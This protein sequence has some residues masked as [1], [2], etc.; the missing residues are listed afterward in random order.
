MRCCNCLAVV[1]IGWNVTC[2]WRVLQ[3]DSLPLIGR[4][5]RRRARFTPTRA[6]MSRRSIHLW[7]I[8]LLSSAIALPHPD[9]HLDLPIGGFLLWSPCGQVNSMRI[10]KSAIDRPMLG[11][12][13]GHSADRSAAVNPTK[14]H[15]RQQIQC[16]FYA[17]LH[18]TTI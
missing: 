5:P 12:K 13:A 8:E 6:V 9:R 2:S 4:Q 3:T 18:R 15:H 11:I 1:M 16:V 14:I 10:M 17:R 7:L